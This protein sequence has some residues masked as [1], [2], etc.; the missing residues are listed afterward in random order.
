[1]LGIEDLLKIKRLYNEGKKYDEISLELDIPEYTIKRNCSNNC[2]ILNKRINK[3][4]DDIEKEKEICEIIKNSSNLNCVCKA[5]GKRATNNNYTKLRKI[6]KK[7]GINTSHFKFNGSKKTRKY[8][9]KEDYF[10][11]DSKVSSSK[12][13]MKLL[14]Y[15]LKPHKC[16]KCGRTTWIFGDME[17]PIPLEAHHIDGDRT[18]NTLDNLMLIC[19]N[20]HT[21]T[22]NYCGKNIVKGETGNDKELYYATKRKKIEKKCEHC[23]KVFQTN[24]KKQKF[25]SKKCTDEHH[26]KCVRP[27]KEELEKLILEKSYKELG[28]IFGVTDNTIRKW[29]IRYGIKLPEKRRHS[30]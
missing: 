18:N 27:P 17:Y 29:C 28:R 3:Y 14:E 22:E 20:C 26:R 1:M 16:E 12:I 6:I 25:C 30:R 8:I 10:T 24:D 11:K 7:Y 5:L 21:F 4:Y 23:Q 15:G 9:T 13:R 2:N 19:P